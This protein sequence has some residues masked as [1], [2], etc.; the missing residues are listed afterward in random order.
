MHCLGRKRMHAETGQHI[1]G[2]HKLILQWS[3]T[4]RWDLMKA[5]SRLSFSGSSHT[6]YACMGVV[7][8]SRLQLFHM[9]ALAHD[10]TDNPAC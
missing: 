2:T 1:A 6:T 3:P 4:F 10:T 8:R 9:G 5:H 7:I